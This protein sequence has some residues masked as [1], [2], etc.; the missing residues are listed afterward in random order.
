MRR[1]EIK[2]RI[3]KLCEDDFNLGFPH[4]DCRKIT[5]LLN[6]NADFLP[7]IN[8]FTHSLW[9]LSALASDKPER[10]TKRE[11][12]ELEK[13]KIWLE[14]SFFERWTKYS[15]AKNLITPEFTP[16]L[17]QSLK[18]NEEIRELILELVNDEL[19][20]RKNQIVS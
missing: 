16:Q 14:K 18:L 10:L 7:D 11:T 3:L 2:A 19:Q 4:E 9:S 20:N 5:K 17:F 13:Y 1:N 6:P 8:T 12:S 15:E